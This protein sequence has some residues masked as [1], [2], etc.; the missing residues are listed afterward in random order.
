MLNTDSMRCISPVG[1]LGNGFDAPSFSKALSLNP[2]FIGADAGSVDPG[3]YYLGTS[4]TLASQRAIEHDLEI[5]LLGARKLKVPLIVGSAFQNGTR[6]QLRNA[7]ETVVRLAHRHGLRF[8]LMAVDAEVDKT[9]LQGKISR[10]LTAPLAHGTLLN[11]AILNRSSCIV[12]QM[13]VDVLVRALESG[14][15][16]VL[17]GRCCDDAIFAAMP[18]WHGFDRALALH[19]GKV[20]EC[21][22]MVAAP[23]DPL[24]TR[25]IPMLGE[26]FHDRFVV[27]PSSEEWF[28]NPRTVA[29]HSSY[30]RDDPI[31]E[32]V[33]GGV[34]DLELCTFTQ[35][36]DTRV[37]VRG[38][39][40]LPADKYQVKVEG[41]APLGYRSVCIAGVRDPDL[42]ASMD[43][44][45]S[46]CEED[47]ARRFADLGRLGEDYHLIFR[48]YGKN[49]VMGRLEK[50]RSTLHEV[51]ILIEAIGPDQ[52]S[53]MAVCGYARST[54]GHAHYP[55]ERA[56]AGNLAFPFSPFVIPVGEAYEFTM[57][58]T[59]VLDAPTE[60]FGFEI[61]EV[62]AE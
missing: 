7:V 38:T 30:E 54:L 46:K 12:A 57:Y 34:I 11:A 50:A 8:R 19:M 22:F 2:H 52:G 43:Q 5:L 24:D 32:P 27:Y 18:V 29:A 36:D 39:K 20:L 48:V 40:Y 41:V 60:C 55:H 9:W 37:E 23:Q 14:A 6:K 61:V 15:D 35:L 28:C 4:N 62:G 31:R 42:I 58:H 3:P 45:L 17:A 44:V 13:G 26:I 10:G 53:S 49:G 16:V 47:T 1:F 21:G 25:R 56:T 51:G 33:P 59:V